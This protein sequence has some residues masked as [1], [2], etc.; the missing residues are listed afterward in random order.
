MS[1]KY[2]PNRNRT[3][4]FG[5]TFRMVSKELN[6]RIFS[7]QRVRKWVAHSLS[8]SLSH[9]LTPSLSHLLSHSLSLPHLL[10]LNQVRRIHIKKAEKDGTPL[11]VIKR[12]PITP[13]NRPCQILDFVLTLAGI[14]RLV[15][16]IK[17]IEKDDLLS[18]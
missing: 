4:A 11:A 8:L 15:V 3:D 6:G 17:A 1:L 2:E 10:T 12:P 7:V 9:P 5:K 13:S 14:R 18:L 16:Q